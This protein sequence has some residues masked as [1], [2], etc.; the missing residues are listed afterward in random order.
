MRADAQQWSRRM[1]DAMLGITPSGVGA[2][3]ILAPRGV[4]DARRAECAAAAIEELLPTQVI[5][6]TPI[7]S[8]AR[9]AALT[10]TIH[11]GEPD[12][13]G[14]RKCLRRV[15]DG[16]P[17]RDAANILQWL[18]ETLGAE[19]HCR[20]ERLRNGCE[21]VRFGMDAQ[22]SGDPAIYG[23]AHDRLTLW[24]GWGADG[25]LRLEIVEQNQ[26][27]PRIEGA[28]RLA[29]DNQ[30]WALDLERFMAEVERTA[31][32]AW[33]RLA[34]NAGDAEAA[35]RL[36]NCVGRLDDVRPEAKIGRPVRFPSDMLADAPYL[37]ED[38]LGPVMES[39]VERTA[40]W[41]RE[42]VK[43]VPVYGGADALRRAL[44]DG[45]WAEAA[46]R[47]LEGVNGDDV[48]RALECV[49]AGG[50][51][52]EAA[53]MMAQRAMQEDA[54]TATQWEAALLEAAESEFADWPDA[55]RR[56]A[57]GRLRYAC[58]LADLEIAQDR[59]LTTA[60]RLRVLRAGR[61]E[62]AGAHPLTLAG[63]RH[64]GDVLLQHYTARRAAP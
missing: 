49:Q 5:A 60:E 26:L 33:E 10:I 54:L 11:A 2:T 39:A 13:E 7:P 21:A 63:W 17:E 59:Q 50:S 3:V 15:M 56:D 57:A 20:R 28:V 23:T 41:A 19:W 47:A 32:G 31:P 45:L 62:A 27:S 29:H 30:P 37:Q 9:E 1:G 61:R 44:D 22:G 16:P 4:D 43:G 64:R 46:N 48:R 25:A 24:A 42:M 36:R 35:E 52:L 40:E 34:A 55:Q 51:A 53:P 38:D 58:A 12:S 14:R 18:D 6:V 8:A